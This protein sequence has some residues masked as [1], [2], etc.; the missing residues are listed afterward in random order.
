MGKRI[1]TGGFI[2]Y[3]NDTEGYDTEEVS[4]RMQERR[5]AYGKASTD[6]ELEKDRVR[7][8][9]TESE[10]RNAPERK[11]VEKLKCPYCRN[12]V[13]YDNVKNTLEKG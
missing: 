8:I 11:R 2:S 12:Y 4:S 6:A 13:R 7:I 10:Y 3:R 5:Q 9:M 1:D